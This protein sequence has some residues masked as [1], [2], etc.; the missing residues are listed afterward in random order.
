MDGVGFPGLC[1]SQQTV[2][3]VDDGL[4][5][6]ILQVFDLQH[7]FKYR[8]VPDHRYISRFIDK[9]I[10]GNAEDVNQLF[11]HLDGGDHLAPLILSDNG[12]AGADLFSD[13]LLA[14]SF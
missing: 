4:L 3:D 7:S 1:V 9:V 5:L 12:A 2:D 11:G 6:I 10:H 13:L 14:P 8:P